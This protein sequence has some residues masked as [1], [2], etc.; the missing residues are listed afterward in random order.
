[1]L[2]KTFW[3]WFPYIHQMIDFFFYLC[4]RKSGKSHLWTQNYSPVI[5]A[6]IKIKWRMDGDYTTIYYC[7]WCL[8]CPRPSLTDEWTKQ[9]HVCTIE[10]YSAMKEKDI[11]KFSSKLMELEIIRLNE[12]TQTQKNDWVISLK[13]FLPKIARSFG[14]KSVITGVCK[15]L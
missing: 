6:I 1:M 4:S 12:L 11:I 7:L 3:K 13:N 9:M 10:S 2:W 14:L 8:H 15:Q 5:G